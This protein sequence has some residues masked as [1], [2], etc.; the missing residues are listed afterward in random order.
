MG[1][2]N[3][4]HCLCKGWMFS[5]HAKHGSFHIMIAGWL[6]I[7]ASIQTARIT[8][9][10]DDIIVLQ[11]S[12]TLEMLPGLPDDSLEGHLMS[13]TQSPPGAICSLQTF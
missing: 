1:I 12:N 6:Q 10:E 9:Q 2:K 8:S 11:S 5:A 4:M 3:C 13:I 7:I